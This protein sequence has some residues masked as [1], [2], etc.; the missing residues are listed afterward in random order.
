MSLKLSHGSSTSS[1]YTP[2][3]YNISFSEGNNPLPSFQLPDLPNSSEFSHIGRVYWNSGVKNTFVFIVNS[4]EY[5]S[6][7]CKSAYESVES[8]ANIPPAGPAP[9]ATEP[10]KETKK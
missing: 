2:L 3:Y 8:F 9:A 5:V 10:T 1:A 7:W 6:K 4:P